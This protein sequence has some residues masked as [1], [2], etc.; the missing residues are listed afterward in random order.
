MSAPIHFNALSGFNLEIT[1]FVQAS[2]E[3]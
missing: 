3:G 2:D 1:E